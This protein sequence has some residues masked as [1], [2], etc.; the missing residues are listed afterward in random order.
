MGRLKCAD[1]GYASGKRDGLQ[2]A[3]PMATESPYYS[4]ESRPTKAVGRQASRPQGAGG[5]E[6]RQ[7]RKGRRNAKTTRCAGRRKL[8]SR[9]R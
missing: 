8:E 4:W 7:K 9:M 2:A 6:K 1:T 3:R 5:Q